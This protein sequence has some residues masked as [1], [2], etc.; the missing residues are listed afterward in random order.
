MHFAV[1]L[2]FW[3][4]KKKKK[5]KWRAVFQAQNYYCGDKIASYFCGCKSGIEYFGHCKNKKK[6]SISYTSGSISV[7]QTTFTALSTCHTRLCKPWLWQAAIGFT[8]AYRIDMTHGACHR[9]RCTRPDVY[10]K[11]I[12]KLTL[13]SYFARIDRMVSWKMT[14][15]SSESEDD[16]FLLAAVVLSLDFAQ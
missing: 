5:K 3:S 16:L 11:W 14:D 8:A 4:C 1:K 2:Y 7:V 15:S 9:P 6:L 13:R 10:S 12:Q